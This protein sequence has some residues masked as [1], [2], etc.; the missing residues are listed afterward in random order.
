ML[1]NMRR[2]LTGYKKPR[3]GVK[4]R[5]PIKQTQLKEASCR[6]KRKVGE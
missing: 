3:F 1:S 5:A 2:P 6:K 4:N